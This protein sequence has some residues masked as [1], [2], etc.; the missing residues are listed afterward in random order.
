M[1]EDFWIIGLLALGLW[2]VCVW[3]LAHRGGGSR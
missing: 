3:L 2:L 1:N